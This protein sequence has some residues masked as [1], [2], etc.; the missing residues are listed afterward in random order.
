MA[1]HP[2]G[3]QDRPLRLRV[4]G[5]VLRRPDRA[6]AADRQRGALLG[7][8][9]HRHGDHRH[10][11][12][13]SPA[14]FGQGTREQIGEW[15]PQCFGT[16][17][18]AGRSAPSAPPSPTPAP[19][20]RRS[21]PRASYDEAT[22]EWVLNGQKAWATNGGIAD[23]HVVVASVDPE[24]GSRGQAA[25]VVP[26]GTKGLEQ[27]AKV[28]KH[29]LRASHTADVVLDD[30]RVPGALP[31]RRQGE[32]RRAPRPRR[33]RASSGAAQA[34]MQTFEATPPDRRRPGDRHRPRRLRVRA[35]LRQGARAVRP[36]DHREP[37]DRLHARRHEARDRRR[38]PARLARRPGWAATASRS[39]TPRAR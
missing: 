2:G 7:R 9:R 37:G 17:G 28:K 27:G 30:C 20:S 34:A 15:I 23:V 22:D 21:A 12:W 16:A 11:R 3:G 4:A 25:F 13:P 5:A 18:R 24:L 8:R 38:P 19:T 36:A 33:A 31:A 32:A 26:P 35:R 1:D 6:D 39:R 14:I 29:G 10:R